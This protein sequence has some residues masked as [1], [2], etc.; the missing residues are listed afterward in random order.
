MILDLTFTKALCLVMLRLAETSL[1][2]WLYGNCFIKRA[3]L[4]G[5]WRHTS[6]K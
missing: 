3:G 4:S 6:Q 5:S 1:I 2:I